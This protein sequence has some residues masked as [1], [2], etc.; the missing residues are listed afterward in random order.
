[1]ESLSGSRFSQTLRVLRDRPCLHVSKGE[2]GE[3]CQER[4]GHATGLGLARGLLCNGFPTDGPS[5]SCPRSGLW[6]QM[7]GAVRDLSP[8]KMA[9]STVPWP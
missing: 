7:Q 5:A 4:K 8:Q 2:R 1:M 6:S 3:G 9:D